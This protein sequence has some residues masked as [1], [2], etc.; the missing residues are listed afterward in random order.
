MCERFLLTCVNFV[1]LPNMSFHSLGL[2]PEIVEELRAQLGHKGVT[3]GLLLSFP[4]SA[5]S[6]YTS[7]L[8]GSFL[9]SRLAQCLLPEP[10]WPWA[11][12][13]SPLS[14]LDSHSCSALALSHHFALCFGML[15]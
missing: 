5:L 12:L 7:L 3:L 9:T 13:G 10:H 6:G 1:I 8:C 4:L 15:R 11:E 14:E 2:C